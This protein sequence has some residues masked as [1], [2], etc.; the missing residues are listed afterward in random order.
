MPVFADAN[1]RRHLRSLV[2]ALLGEPHLVP[3]G[4]L[5]ALVEHAVAVEVELPPSGFEIAPLA[6][7]VEIRHAAVIGLDVR[8]HV[9]ALATHVILELAARGAKRV[10]NRDVRILV[11]AVER[12][13]VA[14]DD[15][16]PGHRQRHPH[17][18]A[19][20]VMMVLVRAL[21]HDVAA[22][23]PIVDVLQLVR[24]P[25]Y[26]IFERGARVHISKRDV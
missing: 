24:P 4:E 15:I 16:G 14:D 13:I 1:D 12:M 7:G 20:A 3:D 19:L 22:L 21:D 9:L 18:D 2:A 17:V 11:R 8:F 6:F 26:E 5:L 10:A 25:A 23:D